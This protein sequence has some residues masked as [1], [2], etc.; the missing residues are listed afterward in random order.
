[1]A[2]VVAVD[3][4]PESRAIQRRK[5]G[6][7]QDIALLKEVLACN[8]HTSKR[9]SLMDNFDAVSGVLNT[10]RVLPWATDGKHCLDRYKLLVS[11][12][13]REDRAKS[14]ASGT[15][16]D[17]NEKEQLLSDI[18]SAVNDAQEH[19]RVERLELAKRDKELLQAGERI[20]LQAMNRRGSSA[21][22][23]PEDR[24]SILDETLSA[25]ENEGSKRPAI[26]ELT[27][28][29]SKD[30]SSLRKRRR[31]SGVYDLEETLEAAESTRA[32][33]EDM[34]LCLEKQRLQFE[35]TRAEKIDNLEAQRIELLNS[36]NE[37]QRQAQ[38]DNTMMQMKMMSVMEEMLR[39]LE[40]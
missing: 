8:A 11:C 9:G 25:E 22:N 38:R 26:E 40:R 31:K 18:V 30:A 20:R 23:E 28:V 35:K 16:E 1:M 10:S 3:A 19:C 17:F 24:D 33:Q 15:E 34:R 39:K 29:D 4:P 13:K 12:F 7:E 27:E 36:Q 37:M 6:E 32:K 5:F 14:R 2:E 21:S